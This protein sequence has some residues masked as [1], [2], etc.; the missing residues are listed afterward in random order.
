MILSVLSLASFIP[1]TPSSL[2]VF[3]S[4]RHVPQGWT[5]LDR[6]VASTRLRLRIALQEADHALFEKTLFEI[7][8]PDHA[9]YGQ[10]LKREEVKALITPRNES[11]DA[12]MAWL[13]ESGVADSDIAN[14]GEWINFLVPV[15]KAE[16]MM[17]TTFY[18]FTQD[19][20]KTGT[21]KIRTLQYSV[22]LEVAP[23]ITMIQ[24]TTRFGFV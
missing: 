11:T 16:E 14:D 7:S 24:P 20:D 10:H 21:K 15:S 23:H 3:E 2:Q 5:K 9:K 12:V 22:P 18:Y 17:N 13:G 1:R 19:A 4:L 6:P 8:D